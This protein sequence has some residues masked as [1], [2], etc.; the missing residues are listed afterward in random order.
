MVRTETGDALG[1]VTAGTSLGTILS[2][3]ILA[4]VIAVTGWREALVW[5]GIIVLVALIPLPAI[6]YRHSPQ[7]LGLTPDGR[8]GDAAGMVRMTSARNWSPREAVRTPTFWGCFV[9]LLLGVVAYQVLTTHQVAHAADRGIDQLAGNLLGGYLS[10]RWG[11][12]VVFLIGSLLGLGAIGALATVSGPEDLWKLHVYALAVGIGF[13]ARISLLSAIPADAFG[14]PSFGL[15]LGLMQVGSGLDGFIGPF[16]GGFV[17]DVTA[18]YAIAF[19]T[20]AAVLLSGVAAWF[21]RPPAHLR[22]DRV[23]HPSAGP[24]I[25]S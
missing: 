3:P 9:M 22:G 11:R 10:D 19:A 8:A 24:T 14:G 18:R 7:A 6:L 20:A 25:R 15:I 2:L 4:Q 13:G 1:V 12:Q 16:L 23:E 21:A 17:Y 5:Y